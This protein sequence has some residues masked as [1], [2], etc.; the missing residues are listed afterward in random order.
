MYIKIKRIKLILNLLFKNNP[1]GE[2]ESRAVRYGK[3]KNSFNWRWG[4]PS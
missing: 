1:K 4:E 2:L 3:N